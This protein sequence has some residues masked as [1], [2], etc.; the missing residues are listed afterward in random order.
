MLMS[1]IFF[2]LGA[3]MLLIAYLVGIKK[4]YLLISGINTASEEKR[5]RM[6]LPAICKSMGICFTIIGLLFLI[7]GAMTLAGISWVIEAAFILF[8]LVIWIMIVYVQ[9]FDG[10]LFDD[11]GR[12]KAQYYISTITISILMFAVIAVGAT[13]YTA[14]IRSPRITMSDDTM[15]IRGMYGTKIQKSDISELMLLQEPVSFTAKTNGSAVFDSYKGNFTSEQ[16]GPVLVY[17][18][19]SSQPWLFIQRSKGKPVLI[20]LKTSEETKE[21]YLQMMSWIE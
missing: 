20:S 15:V 13:M 19:K 3:L 18:K 21:L 9:R 17:A 6:N 7:A 12:P 10:N 5:A 11:N 2:S 14:T 4:M 1:V 16:Y 8:F